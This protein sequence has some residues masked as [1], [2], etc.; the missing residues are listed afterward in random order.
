MVKIF[1]KGMI[2]LN[3]NE[4]CKK[5]VE[6]NDLRDQ[7]VVSLKCWIVISKRMKYFLFVQEDYERKD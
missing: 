5:S 7:D 6:Y 4:N 2:V 1:F 3:Y